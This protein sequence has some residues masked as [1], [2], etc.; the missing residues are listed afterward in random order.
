MQGKWWFLF[1]IRR[2]PFP[3]PHI[4]ERSYH[5]AAFI[6]FITAAVGPPMFRGTCILQLPQ[7]D[8]PIFTY[9]KKPAGALIFNLV[10]PPTLH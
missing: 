3:T 9:I 5:V 6:G 10:V 8:S 1:T 4:A 7:R 2:I